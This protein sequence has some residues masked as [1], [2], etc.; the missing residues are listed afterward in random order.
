METDMTRT[1]DTRELQDCLTQD[2]KVLLLDVRRVEDYSADPQSIPGAERR[3]PRSIDTWIA[4]LPRSREIVIYCVR[5]G[6]VSNSVLDRLLQAGFKAR[7]LEGGLEAW[8]KSGGAI[9]ETST[10][11]PKAER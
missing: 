3:D 9:S 10:C 1:L 8:K 5:D 6:S 4:A 2:R 11:P 7:Y